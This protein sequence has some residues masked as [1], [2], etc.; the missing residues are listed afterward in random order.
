M[1]YLDGLEEE[2]AR[3]ILNY[4]ADIARKSPCEKS[5]RGVVIAMGKEILGEGFNSPPPGF[6]CEREKCYNIC[7]AYAMHAE[8]NAILDALKKGKELAQATMYHIKVKDGEVKTSGDPCCPQC[9]K[10]ALQA[11]I[12]EFVLLHDQ[13]VGLYPMYE[14]HRISLENYIAG[15]K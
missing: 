6:F 4:A 9:S 3:G 12:V 8:Q 10:M 11:G 13:G 2:S 7:N 1:R 14:F 5:K 15:N